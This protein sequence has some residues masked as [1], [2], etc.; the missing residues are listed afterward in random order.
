M[1]ENEDVYKKMCES[2]QTRIQQLEEGLLNNTNEKNEVEE[3]LL[4]KQRGLE[5]KFSRE[6]SEKQREV[7]REKKN[8]A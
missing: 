3:I 5:I 2:M 8:C 4:M 6:L 1:E 7:E